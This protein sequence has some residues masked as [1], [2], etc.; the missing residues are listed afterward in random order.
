MTFDLRN[1]IKLTTKEADM[2]IEQLQINEGRWAVNRTKNVEAIRNIWIRQPNRVEVLVDPKLGDEK[3]VILKKDY[4]DSLISNYKELHHAKNN[5][6]S[7]T[8][9]LFQTI[10][11]LSDLAEKDSPKETLNKVISVLASLRN[12]FAHN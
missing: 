2:A 7:H 5:K 10:D 3:L 8:D 4:L 1:V 12:N 9:T 11:L 6:T